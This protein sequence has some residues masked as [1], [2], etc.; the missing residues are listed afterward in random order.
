MCSNV[1]KNMRERNYTALIVGGDEEANERYANWLTEECDVETMTDAFSV[2][3]SLDTA[4]IVVVNGDLPALRGDHL[5]SEIERRDENCLTA[6]IRCPEDADATLLEAD[7][8]LLRPV[9]RTRFR[10]AVLRLRQQ[11]QYN[12]M[13]DELTELASKCAKLQAVDQAQ[14]DGVPEYASLRDRMSQ[15]KS[16]LDNV[17]REFSAAEYDI[18]FQTLNAEKTATQSTTV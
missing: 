16:D 8:W 1:V 3:D 10:E 2:L 5:L 4:D 9:D 18:A 12:N 6:F 14:L 15:L 11:V 17:V 7:T 13:L